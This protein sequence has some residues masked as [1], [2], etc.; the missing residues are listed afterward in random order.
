MFKVYLFA[1][2]LKVL[3]TNTADD[4]EIYCLFVCF[5]FLFFFVCLFFCCFFLF[6]VVV[7]LLFL[8]VK[9]EDKIRLYSSC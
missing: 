1:L 5:V 2:A 6:F 8:L 3:I 9:F 4:T 7:F